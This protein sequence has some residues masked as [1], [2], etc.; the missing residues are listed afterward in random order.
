MNQSTDY[1]TNGWDPKEKKECIVELAIEIRAKPGKFQ[2]LHQTLQAL[3]PTIRNEK[4]CRKCR[5]YRDA[6]DGKIF[7]LSVHWETEESMEHYMRSNN[8]MALLGAINLLSERAAVK[9]GPDARWDGIDT[10]K[11]IK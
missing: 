2:E 4:S 1:S 10:L 5:I 11:R 8:G 9:T 3:F 6:E 7:F